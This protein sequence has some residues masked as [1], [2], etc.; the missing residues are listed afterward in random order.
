MRSSLI[1][2]GLLLGCGM[3]TNGHAQS[4]VIHGAIRGAAEVDGI[5]V[6]NKTAAHFAIS[7]TEGAFVIRA[8]LNDTILFSGISYLPKEIR[9]TNA[10]LVSQKMDVVLEEAINVLDEVVVG[11]VLTGE[12]LSDIKNAGL[13]P[14]LNFYNLGIPGFT[15]KPMTQAERRLYEA[16]GKLFILGGS[17]GTGGVGLSFNSLANAISGRT[18][19]L[20]QHVRLEQADKCL[21]QMRSRFSTELFRH[22]EMEANL[23]TQFYYYCQEDPEFEKL[24]GKK[25]NMAIFGFLRAK[26]NAFMELL[27]I[28][29][30]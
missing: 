14:K 8:K 18:K 11:K 17:K 16:T 6:I 9:I 28:E 2:V 12:L 15:G 7:N 26:L 1:I 22:L 21:D 3:N 13:K 5:H 4:T 24:C 30:E 19:K 27:Q 23:K 29:D 25:D 20:E 10:I